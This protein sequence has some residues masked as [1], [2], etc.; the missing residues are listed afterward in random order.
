MI[1]TAPSGK[2]YTTHPGSRLLFPDWDVTTADLPPPTGPP[3]TFA[4]R[5]LMMPR[6]HHTR[7]AALAAAIH[8]ERELNKRDVPPF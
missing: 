1:W 6:R 7:A 3:P 5:A 4:D 8:A 2:T